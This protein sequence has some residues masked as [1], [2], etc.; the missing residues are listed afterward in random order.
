MSKKKRLFISLGL[1]LFITVLFAV[2]AQV[3]NTTTILDLSLGAIWVFIL[4]AIIA[5]SLSHYLT[6]MPS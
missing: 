2:G 5:F 4:S 6:K 1:P 3:K